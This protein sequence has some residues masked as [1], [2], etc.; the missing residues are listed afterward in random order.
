MLEGKLRLPAV[1]MNQM[2]FSFVSPTASVSPELDGYVR[3]HPASSAYH[4]SGWQQAVELAYGY[5]CQTLVARDAT[6]DKIVGLLPLCSVGLPLARARWVSL[7]FCDLGGP[8]ADSPDILH[9]L[10][11]AARN[12]LAGAQVKQLELRC[13]A[14][15]AP[16]DESVLIGQKVRMLLDLPDSAE[17]LMAQYPPKLRSQIRKAEKNGL[18]FEVG[19]DA[20]S[21]EGFYQVYSRNMHRLGSPP[22]S[23]RWFEMIFQHYRT[24]N[25][26]VIGSVRH[27]DKV[28][29]AGLV[30]LCG[31]KAVIPWA[32]TLAAY[33]SMAPNMLLYWG[34]QAYLCKHGIRQF[35]FGRSTYAGGTYKFKKQ[36]G[37][38]PLML[39]WQR[40]TLEGR[41][42]PTP[43]QAA[44]RPLI[45]VRPLIESAWRQL[46][47]AITTTVGPCLRKFI[48]L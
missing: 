13:S 14:A 47:L 34:I 24:G 9:E 48:T 21:L 42:S 29:G 4:L 35:D 28:V 27:Q 26:I 11:S 18:V 3:Q 40:W 38:Q 2:T 10:V 17:Q 6:D 5:R 15:A 43:Q 20:A 1:T 19:S 39:E 8:L 12:A 30:L 41:Q 23:R 7:P 46:P 36:W 45:A 37:A 16:H 22:H 25:S 44:R 31:N 32:S 33:N